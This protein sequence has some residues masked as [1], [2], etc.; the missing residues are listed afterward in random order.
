MVQLLECL[1][2]RSP[3]WIWNDLR[4]DQINLTKSWL[5]RLRGNP[6]QIR[7]SEKIDGTFESVRIRAGEKIKIRIAGNR[8]SFENDHGPG[9]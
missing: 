3:L 4:P 2:F 6:R 5:D 7:E 8:N 1:L 9:E